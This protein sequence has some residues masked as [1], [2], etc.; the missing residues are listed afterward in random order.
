MKVYVKPTLDVATIASSAPI[1]V[2]CVI[3]DA[4]MSDWEYVAA[5]ISDSNGSIGSNVCTDYEYIN[6]SN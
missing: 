2:N 3:L 5:G 6:G 1:A 4:T